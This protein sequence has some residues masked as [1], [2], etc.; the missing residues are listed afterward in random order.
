MIDAVKPGL[1]SWYSARDEIIEFAKN[2]L[3]GID[4]ETI[5]SSPLNR[6]TVGILYPKTS[7]ELSNSTEENIIVVPGLEA[8]S[9]QKKNELPELD[10]V[11]D[12]SG[13]ATGQSLPSSMGLTVAL[14]QGNNSTILRVAVQATRYSQNAED[15]NWVPNK[16]ETE[17]PI[18]LQL[19][20]NEVI[21]LAHLV[22]GSD[23][24]LELRVLVRSASHQRVR[25]TVSL[26]NLNSMGE[27]KGKKDAYCWYRPSIQ[28]YSD[29]VP[30]VSS[31]K[32]REYTNQD[33][34]IRQSEFLYRKHPTIAQGHGCSPIWE[35]SEGPIHQ[36]S[37]TFFPS[38]EVKRSSAL[39][40]GPDDVLG[41]YDL[42]M[43]KIATKAGRDELEKLSS[44][45]ERWIAVQE[46]ELDKEELSVDQREIG[47]QNLGEARECL[48]R[49]RTGIG[50]LDDP[51]VFRAFELMNLAMIQQRDASERAK[52]QDSFDSLE[53]PDRYSTSHR[54]YPFQIA[55]IL[56][57]IPAMSDASHPEREIAD[58]LWFPTGGGK[59]EAYL[60]CIAFISLLRRIRN[61]HDGG[62]SA[63]MRYTLRILTT[64][65]FDRAAKLICA[66]EI[67]RRE[68]LPESDQEIS[69]GLWVGD[70]TSFNQL[71]D[72]R[73]E[74]GQLNSGGLKA[75]QSRLLQIKKCPH[76][77]HEITHEDYVIGAK[78]SAEGLKISCPRTTCLFNSGLPLYIVDED[79]YAHRPT[80][81]IGTVDKFAQMTW[82]A[83]V[84]QL[85]SL[86]G[87]FSKPDLIVQDE[88]HLI[89]GPLG[90]MV[91]LYETALDLALTTDS[92]YKCK[93]IASTATIRRA[94]EQV[95]AVFDRTAAQFPPAGLTP[96]DN[97]FSKSADRKT[98]GTRQYVGVISSEKSHATLL[99][100]LYAA[101]LQAAKELDAPD[102]VV[103]TYST[104]LGYFNSL[105]VLGSAY[106]QVVDDIPA[107]I[108]VISER[109][110][111]EA[112]FE[113]SIEPYELTSRVSAAEILSIRERMN[114]RY[115][116]NNLDVVLATNMISVG[117]DIDRLGLMVVAGQP[118]NTSEYIQA[119][120]RVGRKHPGLVFVAFNAQ[121]SRDVSH[122]EGFVTFHR[123][124]YRAVEATTATPFAARARDRGAHGM[125]VAALRMLFSELRS[126][127][128][129]VN[130]V[131]LSDSDKNNV[132]DRIVAR[133]KRIDETE[134]SGISNWEALRV[135]LYQLLSTWESEVKSGQILKFGSMGQRETSTGTTSLLRAA[136][137]LRAGDSP[138]DQVPWDTLTSL[139]DVDVETPL[140]LIRKPKKE[141]QNANRSE[142]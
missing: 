46:T 88:L 42:N 4:G 38:Q 95:R 7:A 9:P 65:Q 91:G 35:D 126:D 49:I 56:M 123:A 51:V 128:D 37:T 17:I 117:L 97:Y 98:T 25:V 75:N 3:Q 40:G 133:A 129:V 77:G 39:S 11:M 121:R 108:K 120:S 69:L 71:K 53:Q 30:F 80:L 67:L 64:D 130:I 23:E 43:G 52:N 110:Q 20:G 26:V 105:R 24:K 119:T 82:K 83:E 102:E 93:I 31:L 138:T 44:A 41:S 47:T 101:L 109:L 141:T 62:V 86:D 36:V 66:L 78:G 12:F 74:L 124:L 15:E 58:L 115:P 21:K 29:E 27:F 135:L 81:V 57:N 18:S 76:C 10:D 90:T 8:D 5:S 2:E 106:L 92:G 22:E 131:D 85:F 87:K 59:T 122:F 139:R 61:P 34:G 45:Y 137:D 19:S 73:T 84:S 55:F 107:R 118:Q 100:R 116:T 54:W 50:S 33:L 136:K 79:L 6:F 103:D 13:S 89:S 63:I 48:Q 1:D 142:E 114:N 32:K 127:S 16:V 104:L 60:G 96:E 125:L 134:N 99:V 14:P 72:A 68:E 28:L 70:S 112:R 140:H 132:I 94:D 111:T 113:K